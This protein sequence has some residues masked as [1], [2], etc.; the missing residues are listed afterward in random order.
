MASVK[1]PERPRAVIAVLKLAI[2]S[3]RGLAAARPGAES[4]PVPA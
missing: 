3:R 4:E 1:G 2:N